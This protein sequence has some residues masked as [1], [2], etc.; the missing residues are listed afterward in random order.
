MKKNYICAR[1]KNKEDALYW[2]TQFVCDS[3]N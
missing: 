1:F 3:P 2:K